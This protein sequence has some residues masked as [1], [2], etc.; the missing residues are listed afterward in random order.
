MESTAA[1]VGA[2]ADTFRH[3][4]ANF[5]RSRYQ[6]SSGFDSDKTKALLGN[7]EL[8]A[9]GPKSHLSYRWSQNVG[10]AVF[11]RGGCPRSSATSNGAGR[12]E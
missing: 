5:E 3:H 9:Q 10:G 11:N 12:Y 6:I 2:V 7:W 8:F 4:T 1:R